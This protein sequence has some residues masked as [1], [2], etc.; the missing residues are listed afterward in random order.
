MI[1][2]RDAIIMKLFTRMKCPNT[3][4][5]EI[6]TNDKIQGKHSI[7]IQENGTPG[8]ISRLYFRN[9]LINI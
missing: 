8:K 6:K 3:I 4:L 7:R 1:F 2:K 5:D 9:V